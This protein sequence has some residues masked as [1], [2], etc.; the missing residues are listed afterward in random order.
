MKASAHE[1]G[2]FLKLLHFMDPTLEL[3]ETACARKYTNKTEEMK[4]DGSQRSRE[5]RS[6]AHGA[7]REMSSP[8]RVFE[9]LSKPLVGSAQ[10]YPLGSD[11]GLENVPFRAQGSFGVGGYRAQRSMGFKCFKRHSGSQ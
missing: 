1:P 5:P 10:I 4:E 9:V 7:Y 11:G 3:R 2:L 6:L 8:S